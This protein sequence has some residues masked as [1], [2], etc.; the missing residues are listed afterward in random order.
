ML[1]DFEFLEHVVDD[2]SPPLRAIDYQ[3][4][5][6]WVLAYESFPKLFID[7]LILVQCPAHRDERLRVFRLL[8]ATF[9]GPHIVFEVT[10]AP[11]EVD[12]VGRLRIDLSQQIPIALFPGR[13]AI[14]QNLHLDRGIQATV[15]SEKQ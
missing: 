14:V 12:A 2:I 9:E 4:N 6:L 10:E 8:A 15:L 7:F 11:L 13:V 5:G 1:V 3:P